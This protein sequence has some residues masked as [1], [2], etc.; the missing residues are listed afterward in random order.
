VKASKR[1]FYEST[2]E[3]EVYARVIT[4]I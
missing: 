1:T 2:L 3:F 4:V